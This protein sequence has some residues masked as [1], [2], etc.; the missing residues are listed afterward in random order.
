MEN[1]TIDFSAKIEQYN[2]ELTEIKK[3]LEI[4]AE[5]REKMDK[6]SNDLTKKLE[7]VGR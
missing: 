7:V 3:C 6:A 2:R 5:N 4:L 1:K